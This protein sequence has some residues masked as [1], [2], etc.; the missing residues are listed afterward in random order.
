MF[1]LSSPTFA[2]IFSQLE[3]NER[4]L[5]ANARWRN[6]REKICFV[7]HTNFLFTNKQELINLSNCHGTAYSLT[8]LGVPIKPLKFDY[9]NQEVVRS[10]LSLSKRDVDWFYAKLHTQNIFCI[11]TVSLI[12]SCQLV[13]TRSEL[14]LKVVWQIAAYEW[15]PN[16]CAGYSRGEI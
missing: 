15:S 1:L 3:R 11:I 9:T 10:W 16:I 13:V 6:G 8:N 2:Y 4:K 12:G 7:Q 5:N 14:A